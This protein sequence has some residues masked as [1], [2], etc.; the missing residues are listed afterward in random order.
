MAKNGNQRHRV[1]LDVIYPGESA[2]DDW[3]ERLRSLNVQGFVSPEHN[4]DVNPDGEIKKPH[5]HVVLNFDSPKSFTQV[6]EIFDALGAPHP[7]YA[8]SYQGAV[9]YLTHMD[10]PEKHPYSAEDVIALGGADYFEV[11]S[12]AAD[13]D[14]IISEM[15][16][17]C[18]D[19]ACYSYAQLCRY[20]RK[21]KP[22]WARMLRHKCTVH[23]KAYLQSCQWELDHPSLSV[24]T[25]SSILECQRESRR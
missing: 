3:L 17:W 9:R 11:V 1:W 20:A 24:N 12:R 14:G 21:N 8:Q 2:P 22:E 16:Q 10:N 4:L 6:C 18:D 25:R 23:M 5:R 7:Q 13:F 19:T 15:E